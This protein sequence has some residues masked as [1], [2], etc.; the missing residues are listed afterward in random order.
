ML[1]QKTSIFFC[2][3][4]NENI[5]LRV[6]IYKAPLIHEMEMIRQKQTKLIHYLEYVRIY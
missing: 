5:C 1:F 4:G 6:I 2:F 3:L